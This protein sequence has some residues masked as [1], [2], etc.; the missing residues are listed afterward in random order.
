MKIIL[1]GASGFLGEI[2][3]QRLS[4]FNIITVGRSTGSDIPCDLAKAIPVLPGADLIIH[5]AGK[6]HVVPRTEAEKQEF[7]EVNVKGTQ[8]LLSGLEQATSLPKS[9]VFI[10][11]VAVYGREE[12]LNLN[13]YTPLLAEDPYGLSKINAEKVIIDWCKKNNVIC[14][15][16]RL[17]LLVGSNAPGNLG[18]MVKSIQKG[19]Y[20]NIAGGKAKKSMVL[21]DDVARIIPKAA[22]I[23]GIFNLTDRYH[24]SFFELSSAI[25]SQYGKQKPLSLPKWIVSMIA[26]VGNALGPK[27]PIN[28]K[29]LKKITNDLTFN[30]D[31]AY[32]I[33]DWTPTPV[34]MSYKTT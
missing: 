22:E 32:E 1:T 18:V 4:S 5:S 9:F 13:E 24:P 29:K 11:S 12:G 20:L 2:I 8:N 30:D 34:L 7:F 10:S 23:G 33:L 26:T 31:K 21:A 17:P 27:F 19:L 16:L 15:I 6:A 14:T 3:H 25:A 28:T